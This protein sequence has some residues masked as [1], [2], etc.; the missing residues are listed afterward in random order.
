MPNIVDLVRENV[1][2]SIPEHKVER[3]LKDG[4]KRVADIEAEAKKK[5]SAPK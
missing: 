1:Y 2:K 3:F 5:S 4:F